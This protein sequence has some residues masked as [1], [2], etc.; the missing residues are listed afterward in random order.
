[1]HLSNPLMSDSRTEVQVKFKSLPSSWWNGSF[2]G[3]SSRDF[4]TP[5]VGGRKVGL[6]GRGLAI[7]SIFLEGQLESQAGRD[8]VVGPP[9]KNTQVDPDGEIERHDA[10]G[11]GTAQQQDVRRLW[12]RRRG[13]LANSWRRRRSGERRRRR[14]GRRERS[15]GGAATLLRPC[16]ETG[17]ADVTAAGGREAGQRERSRASESVRSVHGAFKDCRENRKSPLK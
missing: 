16:A 15:L 1:M 2:S 3:F 9:R 8:E 5:W 17:A 13:S 11:R 14:A 6:T 7:F 10:R 4:S 12:L